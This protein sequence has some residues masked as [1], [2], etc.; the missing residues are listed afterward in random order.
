MNTRAKKKLFQNLFFFLNFFHFFFFWI[1]NV[2]FFIPDIIIP[3]FWSK[4][5]ALLFLIAGTLIARSMSD[6]WLIQTITMI[7]G[8]VV[9]MDK[10]RF[11]S[12]ILR[13]FSALPLV[14]KSFCDILNVELIY[15]FA[16]RIISEQIAVINNV[17]KW[18]LGELKLRFRTNLSH[19]LYNQY[20][21][22]V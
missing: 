1:D 22:W 15:W 5:C 14:M 16:S 20:L 13:Y 4:E 11:R 17:L 10:T 12:N 18:G 19:H 21:K 2:L 7:E 3:G 8:A 9:T 6:V